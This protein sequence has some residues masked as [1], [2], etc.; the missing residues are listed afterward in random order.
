MESTFSIEKCW[1]YKKITMP[2]GVFTQI[3]I[4][5]IILACMVMVLLAIRQLTHFEGFDNSEETSHLREDVRE[6]GKIITHNNI[7]STLVE[8]EP[9]KKKENYKSNSKEPFSRRE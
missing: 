8:A 3:V 1:K 4:L 2:M 7:F 9:E 6:D 5:L